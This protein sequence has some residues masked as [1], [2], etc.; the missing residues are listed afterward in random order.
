MCMTV[1]ASAEAAPRPRSRL[2]AA[3]LTL[4]APGV[5]HLYVGQRR[6]AL[7]IVILNFA[8]AALYVGVAFL[9]PPALLPIAILGLTIIALKLVY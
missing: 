8:L 4:L 9:L 6:R 1:A 2:L 3:F 5:G 7:I